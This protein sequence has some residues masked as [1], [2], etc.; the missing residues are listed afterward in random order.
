MCCRRLAL[1]HTCT[2]CRIALLHVGMWDPAFHR[3]YIALQASVPLLAQQR[4][5]YV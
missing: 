1:L 5:V 2:C 3:M 4:M